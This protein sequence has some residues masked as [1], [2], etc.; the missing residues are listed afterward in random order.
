MKPEH[1]KQLT[2]IVEALAE[3]ETTLQSGEVDNAFLETRLSDT[4]ALVLSGNSEGLT[5][6]GLAILKLAAA[7]QDGKHLRFCEGAMLDASAR[8]LVIAY[9]HKDWEVD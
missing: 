2:E 7:A 5:F 4:G 1:K 3:F 9:T 6:L 8:D